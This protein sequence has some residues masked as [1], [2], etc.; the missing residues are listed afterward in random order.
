MSETSI[1]RFRLSRQVPHPT[2]E[3]QKI[4]IE[5]GTTNTEEEAK[6]LQA[7]QTNQLLKANPNEQLTW[8]IAPYYPIVKDTST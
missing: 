5:A 7:K 3:N 1:K 6:E 8:L 4:W 2:K